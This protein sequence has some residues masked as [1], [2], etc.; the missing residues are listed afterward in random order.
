MS[1]KIPALETCRLNRLRA[2][3]IPS[4]SPITTWVIFSPFCWSDR[5]LSYQ[6]FRQRVLS[7]VSFSAGGMVPEE[8]RWFDIIE[9]ILLAGK[10]R[11][12]FPS[13]AELFRS[14]KCCQPIQTSFFS[15]L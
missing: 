13:V 7:E 11:S 8:G 9:T 10:A 15:M 3:S 1:G 6:G 14:K 4:F 2:D 12:R 5:V